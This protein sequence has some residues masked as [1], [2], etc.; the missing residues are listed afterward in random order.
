LISTLFTNLERQ[1]RPQRITN[2]PSIFDESPIFEKILNLLNHSS[3]DY[4]DGQQIIIDYL[5]VPGYPLMGLKDTAPF[6]RENGH[7]PNIPSEAEVK[8]KGVPLG[9]MESK[10]LA[11]VEE[12]T[13]HMIQADER[14]AARGRRSSS[15]PATPGRPSTRARRLPSRCPPAA[16]HSTSAPSRFSP[17]TVGL[18]TR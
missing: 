12:L 10:F 16:H 18:A 2:P 4:L 13:L 6:I 7:L 1:A 15:P 9:E 8:E 17:P 14:N 11:K 3:S 5:F